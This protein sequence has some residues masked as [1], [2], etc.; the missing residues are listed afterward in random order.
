MFPL[1]KNLQELRDFYN[2]TYGLDPAMR[3]VFIK[4]I[5]GFGGSSDLV[6]TVGKDPGFAKNERLRKKYLPKGV[7]ILMCSLW[8]EFK[9]DLCITEEKRYKSKFVKGYES[10]YNDKVKEVFLVRNCLVHRNG[11]VD[12]KEDKELIAMVSKYAV[13]NEIDLTYEEVNIFFGEMF[14]AFSEI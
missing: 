7:V 11:K 10:Y 2:A 12:V 6:D 8:G 14:K 9:K 4:A 5:T 3:D 1:D 13:G